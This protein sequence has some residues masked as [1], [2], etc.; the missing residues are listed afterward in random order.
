MAVE[1]TEEGE[2]ANGDTIQDRLEKLDLEE[3]ETCSTDEMRE[4]LGL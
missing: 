2:L 1:H 4:R 3:D